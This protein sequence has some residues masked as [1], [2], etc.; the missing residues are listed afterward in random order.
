MIQKEDYYKKHCAAPQPL[1]FHAVGNCDSNVFQSDF[2]HVAASK[3]SKSV[4]TRVSY[5]PRG[6]LMKTT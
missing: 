3:I 2:N 6:I 4:P 1:L 5:M